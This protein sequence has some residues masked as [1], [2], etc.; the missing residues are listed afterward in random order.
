MWHS[1]VFMCDMTLG[2]TWAQLRA[3]PIT[4]WEE[5]IQL[6]VTSTAVV[7][8]RA[9]IQTLVAT[10]RSLQF[11]KC[12]VILTRQGVRVGDALDPVTQRAS[13]IGIV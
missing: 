7:V 8:R 9:C 12:G 3:Q 11:E 5:P 4:G 6:L 2:G 1:F 10:H 13:Q